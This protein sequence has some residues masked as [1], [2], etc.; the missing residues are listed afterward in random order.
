MSENTHLVCGVMEAVEVA[1][2]LPT[3]E[4]AGGQCIQ[5]ERLRALSVFALSGSP[6]ASCVIQ[7]CTAAQ[8]ASLHF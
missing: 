3:K 4:T 7:W 1:L 8:S 6:K 2:F 5:V